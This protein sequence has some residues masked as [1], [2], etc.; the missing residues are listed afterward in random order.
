MSKSRRRFLTRVSAGLMAAAAACRKPQPTTSTAEPTPG[1]P[2]AFGTAPDVGPP[3]SASTF[4]EAEKLVQFPM[5]PAERDTAAG[6]WRKS[7]APLYERRTGPRKHTL[8]ASVSPASQW[9]P[10]LHGQQIAVT[11][12]VTQ[13]RFAP[14]KSDPGPLPSNDEDIAFAPVTKLSR[15]I[16]SRQLTSA[17]LTEI[18]LKRL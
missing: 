16:Q 14:G 11:Q 15:W 1:A 13:N 8:D 5:T 12:N 17:R 18:F 6:N 7:M 3:V 4:A 9:N 2:P 10:V